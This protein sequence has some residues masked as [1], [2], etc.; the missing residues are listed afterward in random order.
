V[1]SFQKK[2]MK[3]SLNRLV[4]TLLQ[5]DDAEGYPRAFGEL[6][7]RDPEKAALLWEKLLP[8]DV[9]P[10]PKHVGT[11]LYEIAGS[12]DRDMA[13]LNLGRFTDSA[14]SP[15]RFFGSIYLEPPICHLLVLVFSCSQY[16]TD[17]L[18]RNPGYL[19]WLIEGGVLEMP[20]S[21]NSYCSELRDH[22]APF[23]DHRRRI[24]SIK[25]YRR[26]EM[27]RVGVRD[28]LG[29]AGV[30]EVTAELS[31]LTDAIVDTI[32]RLSFRRELGE[33]PGSGDPESFFESLGPYHRFAIISMGKLG[34]YELNYSSDIDL[35]FICDVEE[36][37]EE[38]RFYS[39]LAR[40]I[41][42]DLSSPTEEG[43]LYRVDLR[44]RPDGEAGPLVVTVSDHISYLQMRARPWEKQAL[45]KARFTAGN[46]SVADE[47][48]ENCN[49]LIFGTVVG[50]A[51]ITDIHA[52]RERAL[53]S[54]PGKDRETNIKL[55][56]GG[57]RDIEFMTQAL[58]LVHGRTRSEVRSRNTL[59]T[60][61]RLHHFGLLDDEAYTSLSDI[62][63][64]YRT[65]EHRLQLVLNVQTHTV[66]TSD[67]DLVR[68]GARVARSAL[69]GLDGENFSSELGRAIGRI[70]D[71]YDQFFTGRPPE[72]IPVILSLPAGAPEV[73]NVLGRFGMEDAERAHRHL[74]SLVYGDFPDLEGPETLQ[75]AIRSLPV[76]LE[77]IGETPAPDL[78]LKNL[79]A[80]IKATGAARSTLDLLADSGGFLRLL[81][82]VS[83]L[84]TRMTDVLSRRIELL[85]KVAAGI[86]PP[87]TPLGGPEAVSNW[88]EESL[89]H[90]HIYNP[91]PRAGPGTLGPLLSGA[92][93][94]VIERLFDMSVGAEVPV[95]L[96]S[97]G[98]LA[99]RE[100]H[101]G[102]DLDLIAVG[103]EDF[104]PADCADMIRRM[105]GLGRTTRGIS[106]DLRLRGEGDGSPLVQ[107]LEAY[108]AYFEHRASFWEF[109]AFG[110]RRFICGHSETGR[111][112]EQL[113]RR[114]IQERL[115]SP[116][117][118]DE[119][120]A[121]RERLESLSA[122]DW[123]VKH[124]AGGLYDLDFMAVTVRGEEDETISGSDARLDLLAERGLLEES[125]A[126]ILRRAHT[127][128][129]LIE[130]AAAHHGLRYPPLP[131]RTV[132]FER[133]LGTL[134]GPLL[135]GGES[136]SEGL[137]R[138]KRTVRE[139]FGRF[140][141]RWR[142][143][144]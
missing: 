135:P 74:S 80:I 139:I 59:E 128:Y 117:L 129:Y 13:L 94:G 133:Y 112:F 108:R 25:R 20:K 69:D 16:L 130:H 92:A 101:Y 8:A 79:T 7:F 78:T 58:E 5:R 118:I 111:D 23:E 72:D 19:S 81:M 84:S 104:E 42:A 24:N 110:K 27:L 107:G 52:M 34:G 87:E 63:R 53:R 132:F 14:I 109:V 93:E 36:R 113:L 51:D 123:D 18:I 98:S 38:Y 50:I 122:G 45:L 143:C 142:G 21:Y 47:F 91:F 68:L 22:I 95:A 103:G 11:L 15:T 46:A 30:E 126:D 96:F 43:T 57:I 71:L 3:D 1:G 6:G 85:D 55:M 26:R 73:R 70:R 125:E 40:S 4:E 124:A 67:A 37:N 140:C 100:S 106:L 121:E 54:L 120:R 35:L 49:R 77:D 48:L 88:Y 31:L 32:S 44:L 86:P 138:T 65:V 82:T 90:I 131:E 33:G 29:L 97:L 2:F 41:T 39:A 105:I 62:Y 17:I 76:I 75:A 56:R 12:P 134:L 66:P 119:L 141:E 83:S 127:L 89:L 28:L 61:E 10:D 102:S 99:A 64:F 136:F 137:A 144:G 115:S 60:I 116:G 114:R 9:L